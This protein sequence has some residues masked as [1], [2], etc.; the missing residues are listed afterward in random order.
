[1]K[2]APKESKLAVWMAEVWVAQMA[3]SMAE[4]M[5]DSME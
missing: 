3:D 1:M 2:V 4:T 5:V